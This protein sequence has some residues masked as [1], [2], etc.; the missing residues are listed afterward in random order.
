M[1]DRSDGCLLI[2]LSVGVA[3]LL[4]L[5]L[6]AAVMGDAPAGAHR[7]SLLPLGLTCVGAWVFT[8]GVIL[9]EAIHDQRRPRR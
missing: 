2:L 7:G 6:F 1:Y 5:A 8:P 3:S 4:T 9:A